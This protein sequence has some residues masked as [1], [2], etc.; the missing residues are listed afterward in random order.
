LF[1]DIGKDALKDEA[2]DQLESLFGVL[3]QDNDANLLIEGHTDN[4]GSD[5]L[6][7][8]LA[9]ARANAVAKFLTRRGISPGRLTVKGYGA[10]R[11]LVSNDDERDGREINRRIEISI[12]RST[13]TASSK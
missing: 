2:V 13:T 12:Q 11:P 1:F 3:Q 9:I 10:S 6:N 8:A 5:L 7:N 4:T